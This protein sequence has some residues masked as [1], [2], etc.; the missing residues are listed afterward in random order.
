M[1]RGHLGSVLNTLITDGEGDNLS[2]ET[3][4]SE[5]GD[6]LVP[7]KGTPSEASLARYGVP[8]CAMP[9]RFSSF[10]FSELNNA[11]NE[12]SS[13]ELKAEEDTEEKAAPVIKMK[14]KKVPINADKKGAADDAIA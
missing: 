10:P 6:S 9:F 2:T 5:S 8:L 11:N 3:N 14:Q 4:A 12:N 13:D 7:A 1:K